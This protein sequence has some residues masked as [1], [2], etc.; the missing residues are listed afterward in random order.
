M[1]TAFFIFLCPFNIKYVLDL[2]V[3]KYNL[4]TLCENNTIMED[5]DQPVKHRQYSFLCLLLLKLI[6]ISLLEGPGE[7]INTDNC[8]EVEQDKTKPFVN[9]AIVNKI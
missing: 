2:L 4:F 8:G 1:L 9:I 7:D 6:S 3:L 5:S